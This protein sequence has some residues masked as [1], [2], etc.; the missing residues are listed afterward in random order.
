MQ[1]QTRSKQASVKHLLKL[2]SSATDLRKQLENLKQLH[3]S[4]IAILINFVSAKGDIKEF[5]YLSVS[6]KKKRMDTYQRKLLT[7]VLETF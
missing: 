2:R 6:K 3:V 5:E 7:D 4:T 1:E